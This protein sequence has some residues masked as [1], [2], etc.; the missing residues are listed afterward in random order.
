M[1]VKSY[2]SN[3]ILDDKCVFK[4]ALAAPNRIQAGKA[5]LWASQL[6]KIMIEWLY[7]VLID[8]FNIEIQQIIANLQY[9]QN[10]YSM[11]HILFWNNIFWTFWK[12]NNCQNLLERIIGEGKMTL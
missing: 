12:Y 9:L 3:M 8:I 7:K 5:H 1:I 4:S 6:V 11:R 10:Y 2:F